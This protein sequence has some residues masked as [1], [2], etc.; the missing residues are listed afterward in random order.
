MPELLS[1]CDAGHTHWTPG[2]LI[3]PPPTKADVLA[4]LA[5]EVGLSTAMERFGTA[6]SLRAIAAAVA[7]WCVVEGGH[8]WTPGFMDHE[9]GGCFVAGEPPRCYFCGQRRA[10]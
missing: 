4:L 9:D 2:C 10:E 1:R 3:C 6:A 7:S 8:Q 5:E